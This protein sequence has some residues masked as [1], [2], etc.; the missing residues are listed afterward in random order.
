MGPYRD[1]DV[2][3][4]LQLLAYLSKCPHCRQAFYKPRTSFHPTTAQLMSEVRASPSSV[5]S[6]DSSSGANAGSGSSSAGAAAMEK[7]VNTF[8]KVFNGTYS[9]Y[10]HPRLDHDPYAAL[11]PLCSHS[12]R[13]TSHGRSC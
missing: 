8:V 5:S 4:S 11:K 13:S 7:D 6:S 9:G 3:L 10:H 1:E 2:L 12:P